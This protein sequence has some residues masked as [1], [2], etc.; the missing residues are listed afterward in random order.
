[1]NWKSTAAVSG[2]TLLATWLGWT[3]TRYPATTN[4]PRAATGEVTPAVNDIQE[5]AE[6][7]QSR[8]RTE[9]GYSDPKRNPFR[10]AP[11]RQP[12]IVTRAIEPAPQVVMPVIPERLPFTLSGLATDTVDGEVR[13]TVI[14]TAG[15]DVLFV[16][17]GDQVGGYMVSSVDESGVSFT[18]ADGTI[19]RLPLLP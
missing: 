13:R 17:E 3:P 10:F 4:P 11:R 18:G 9:L 12:P 2:V 1:M 15:S 6:R 8:V 14:L 19:R 7:L 5:Q 16:K